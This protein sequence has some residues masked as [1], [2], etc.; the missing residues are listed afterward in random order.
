MMRTEDVFA[1]DCANC[2]KHVEVPCRLVVNGCI[3]CTQCH[4]SFEMGWP[5]ELQDPEPEQ[6]SVLGPPRQL[7]KSVGAHRCTV[8]LVSVVKIGFPKVSKYEFF[9]LTNSQH[10]GTRSD[11]RHFQ[12]EDKGLAYAAS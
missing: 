8:P 12:A 5:A 2:R 4:A 11:A 7:T 3:P 9:K 1:I 10:T 6:R